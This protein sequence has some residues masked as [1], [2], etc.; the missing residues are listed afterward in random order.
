MKQVPDFPLKD[1]PRGA[2]WP[3]FRETVESPHAVLASDITRKVLDNGLTILVKEVYPASVISLSIW[4]RVGSVDETDEIA[5]I[6]H[7]VEHMLFKNTKTRGVG[8]IAREIHSLG[9]Y[10]NGFTSYDCTCYWIVLPSRYFETALDIQADAILN[11][12]FLQEEVE[13][14][15]RVIIE[16]LKMYEDRPDA[17]CFER[18][19]DLAYSRHRYKRSIIG[20][21]DVLLNLGTEDISDYYHGYYKP[22]NMAVVLVGDVRTGD[23]LRKISE[24]LGKLR[25]GEIPWN[26]SPAEPPQKELRTRAMKG[27]IKNAH[28][29]MGYHVPDIFSRDSFA[30]DLLSTIMGEGRSSRLYQSLREKRR[31]VNCITAGVF[32]E[33]YPGLFTVEAVLEPR[34][35]DSAREAIFQEV[36]RIQAEGVTEEEL[37]KAKNIAEA[38]YVFSQETVEGQSKKLGYFEIIGDYTLADRYVKKLYSVTREDILRV[39]HTYLQRENLSVVSYLPGED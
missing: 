38:R 21:E 30:C 22:N 14:E 2:H 33:K 12:L 16:E 3:Q 18:L 6:S 26:P 9:G 39:S 13:K 7:F 35:V 8:Q 36:E 37:Q 11:P 17:Y 23:A 19:M 1:M 28:L 5:G 31:L 15:R 32:V 25:P 34:K 4:A 27:D 10:M 24:T 20:F 29:M